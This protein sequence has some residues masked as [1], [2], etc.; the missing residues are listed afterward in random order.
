MTK[1]GFLLFLLALTACVQKPSLDELKKSI[2]AKLADQPGTYA[3][4]FSNLSS[5]EHL[6]INEHELFHAAST[7]KTPVMVEVYKQ[8]TAGKFSLKDSIIIKNEFFSIV[9]GSLYSLTPDSDSDTLI[10]K[11]LGEKRTIYSLMYDMIIISSNLATN[12]I[13]DLVDAK[14]V[15]KSL[16]EI[17]AKNI[18]VLRGVEDGKAFAAG[19]N[20]QVTA[21]DLMLLFEKIDA[22]EI[23]TN[24]ASM[25]MVDILLDQRFNEII[26]AKLPTNV[27]VAHK[28]GSITGVQHDSGIVYL[29]DGKKYVL[30]LLS[31]NLPDADAGVAVLADISKM[32]Y[33]YVN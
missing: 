4:A 2:E 26:P 25:G 21:Y 5:N 16:R 17:G 7:M 15:T 8:A 33:D 19:L 11:H 14:N 12:L 18:Q 24:E 30:V 27:K 22:E 20:N 23:V 10:Y 3:V 6:F 1:H 9:D 31:K 28:T 13:I 29:P 32:I